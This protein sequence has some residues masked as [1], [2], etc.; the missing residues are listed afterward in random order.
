MIGK[1]SQEN[2]QSM[3]NCNKTIEMKHRAGNQTIEQKGWREN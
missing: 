3:K 1:T 2:D